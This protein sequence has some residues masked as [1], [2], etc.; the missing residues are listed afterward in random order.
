MTRVPL[1]T[2][3]ALLLP[4]TLLAGPSSPSFHLVQSTTNGGGAP[5]S[6]ASFVLDGSAGQESVIGA[7]SSPH[8][9]VQSGFWSFLGS[10]LV[11]VLLT[12][13]KNATQQDDVDLLWTGNNSPYDL[14]AAT[15]CAS[16][17]A[18]YLTTIPGQSHTD[19][20]IPADLTCYAVVAH[21]PGPI[22]PPR[23]VPAADA[24]RTIPP[25]VRPAPLQGHRRR[26]YPQDAGR[27][28]GRPEATAGA[29]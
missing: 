10:S 24:S 26:L 6:S 29:R 9:V 23:P 14:Y 3:I 13:N 25:P 22:T 2:V 18:S 20:P 15:D 17:Y 16:V 27:D 1:T 5:G 11:P 4:A 28:A 8:Y 21:A 19:S 7:S 12:A